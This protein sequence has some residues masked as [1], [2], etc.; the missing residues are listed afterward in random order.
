M[1]ELIELFPN[2]EEDFLQR[3][4]Y[5]SNGKVEEAV[6]A[7]FEFKEQRIASIL[8]ESEKVTETEKES[9]E[10]ENEWISIQKQLSALNKKLLLNIHKLEG[11]HSKLDE[12]TSHGDIEIRENR[13][14]VVEKIE[15]IL[16]KSES[17]KAEINQK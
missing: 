2:F 13:K 15:T 5:S 14:S 10:I 11:H 8:F 6:T 4:L 17:I 3:Y 9:E 12:V 16:K 1:Q 7:I